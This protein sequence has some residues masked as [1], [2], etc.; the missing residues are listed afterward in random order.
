MNKI[1][2]RESVL[3]VVGAAAGRSYSVDPK[4]SNLN[5]HCMR[6]SSTVRSQVS[7]SFLKGFSFG[8][9]PSFDRQI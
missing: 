1:R 7:N 4:S 6:P 5:H 8:G 3:P 2:A 9:T